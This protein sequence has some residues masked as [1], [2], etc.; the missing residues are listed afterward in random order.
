MTKASTPI[1]DVRIDYPRSG[2]TDPVEEASMKRRGRSRT[3]AT[4]I[5]LSVAIGLAISPALPAALNLQSPASAQETG[6][7]TQE[8]PASDSRLQEATRVEL[9]DGTVLYGVILRE[10]GDEVEIRLMS[11]S[12]IVLD[13]GSIENMEV[14]SGVMKGG[15]FLPPDPNRSRL[16]WGPTARTVPKGQGYFGV[17]EIVAPF[18]TFGVSPTDGISTLW[19]TPKIRLLH[20]EKL[21]VAVGSF[22]LFET[23]DNGSFGAIHYAVVTAGDERASVTVGGGM[24]QGSLDRPGALMLGGQVRTSRSV[25]LMAEG[26]LLDGGGL[27]I[28]GPRFLGQK[29]SADVGLGVPLTGD[30]LFVLP[31]VNFAYAW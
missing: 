14:V 21:D 15:A 24:F 29:L 27:L 23:G 25:K 4:G 8:P 22:L 12:T 20:R 17:Y 28:L 30:G 5:G 3:K 26:Y 7:P 18:L 19:L 6:T 16:F 10:A 31:I 13:R 9:D 1:M 11:G 2:P